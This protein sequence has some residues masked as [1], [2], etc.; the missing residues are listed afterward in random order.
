MEI[1][2]RKGFTATIDAMIFIILM[3]LVISVIYSVAESPDHNGPQDASDILPMLL[4]SE[5]K[6][7]TEDG[8]LKVKMCDG[9]V[10]AI[11][12]DC[13]AD[14]AASNILDS[15]F[16]REGA[17]RLTIEHDVHYY[18]I[19]SGDG[20]PTSSYSEDISSEYYTAKYTLALY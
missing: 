15:H 19:G 16:M 8:I 4:E 13:G 7:D 18:S 12:T 14:V 9:L 3:T 5:V 17:Y 6:I 1:K 10:Y 2:G 11:Y 20:I